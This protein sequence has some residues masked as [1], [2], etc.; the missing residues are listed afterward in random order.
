MEEKFVLWAQKW[1]AY[2]QGSY[3]LALVGLTGPIN[4]EFSLSGR[5]TIFALR[6]LL[7]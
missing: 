1:Q 7:V 6:L 5:G 2:I 4:Q 3:L